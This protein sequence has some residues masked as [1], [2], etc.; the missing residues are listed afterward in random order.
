MRAYPA[1]KF[2]VSSSSGNRNSR[3]HYMPP[4]RARNSQTLS[5]ARVNEVVLVPSQHVIKLSEVIDTYY[6]YPEELLPVDLT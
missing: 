6:K 3:G 5:S 1:P 2:G 4:S